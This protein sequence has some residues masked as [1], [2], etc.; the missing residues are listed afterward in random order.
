MQ[1]LNQKCHLEIAPVVVVWREMT[2]CFHISLFVGLVSDAF[3]P[4]MDGS[5]QAQLCKLRVLGLI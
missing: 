4:H 1:P 5:A 2:S 3:R